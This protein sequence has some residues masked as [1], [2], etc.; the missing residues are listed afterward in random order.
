MPPRRRSSANSI[1]EDEPRLL[2]VAGHRERE[3]QKRF[4]GAAICRSI[5]AALVERDCALDPRPVESLP[6]KEVDPRGLHEGAGQA[7]VVAE[8]LGQR[9]GR[10]RVL[11]GG[12]QVRDIHE[13]VRQHA[14]E[15][16]QE[17][18]LARGIVDRFSD[19]IDRDLP[20]PQPEGRRRDH[21]PH[22]LGAARRSYRKPRPRAP[23]H[24]VSRRRERGIPP[25]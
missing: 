8:L 4:C 5:G 24:G 1:L 2:E 9:D 6:G 11:S 15:V 7:S 12:I 16:D 20:V 13:V 23:G 21:R 3:A 25:P 18:F 19:A 22:P 14:L 17:S 10:P